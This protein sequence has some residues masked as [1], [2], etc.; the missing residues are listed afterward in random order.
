M[1]VEN[2]EIIDFISIDKSN[3]I[4]LTISDHLK[5]D[6]KDDHSLILQDK[7]NAYLEVI[8][9]G[10]IYDIYPDA[11]DKNF[12]IQLAMKYKPNKRA[13]DFLESIKLFLKNSNYEFKFYQLKE[14]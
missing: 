5:W 4:V 13:N 9:S 11:K 10:Q 3:K 1:S 6:N 12:I 7:I 8:E 2:K 14:D